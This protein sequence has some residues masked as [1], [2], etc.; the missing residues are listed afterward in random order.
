LLADTVN[1][2]DKLSGISLKETELEHM[3]EKQSDDVVSFA[4]KYNEIV[5]IFACII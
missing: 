1:L 2:A 5:S 3:T 4:E